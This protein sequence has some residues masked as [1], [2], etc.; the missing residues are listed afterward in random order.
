MGHDFSRRDKINLESRLVQAGPS[1]SC[2]FAVLIRLYSLILEGLLQWP[3]RA[4][5]QTLTSR[6]F[7]SRMPSNLILTANT[8]SLEK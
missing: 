1:S 2:P 3:I 8:L 6:N 4:M 5:S 7:S